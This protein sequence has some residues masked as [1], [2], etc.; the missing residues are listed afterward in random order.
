MTDIVTVLR[1]V[2]PE[3]VCKT[4]NLVNGGL[5]KVAVAQ[6]T[7][8]NAEPRDAST[9]ENMRR[10]LQDAS[11]TTNVALA[12]GK[13]INGDTPFAVVPEAQLAEML[14][15]TPGQVAGGVHVVS[16]RRIAA[17]LKRGF[18][19][20]GWVL[21]DAD[22]P[23]GMPSDWCS[24]SIGDRL[25]LFEKIL[26]GIS[27]CERIELRS[28]SARV[29]KTG[30]FGPA[31]HAYIRLSDPTKLENLRSHVQIE[32]V[33]KGLAFDSPR[34]SR[35][36]PGRVIGH[37]KRT[38]FD[39]AVWV[40]GRLIF[41]AKPDVS[42][43]PGYAVADADIRIVNEGGGTLDLGWLVVV[44]KPQ[45]DEYE[46]KTGHRVHFESRGGSLMCTD[47]SQ[48]TLDTEVEVRGKTKPLS[49][50]LAQVPDDGKLRC[51]TPFRA[52]NSEAA[53]IA[54]HKD[55]A[56]FLYDV[57]TD[58]KYC[59]REETRVATVAEL[60]VD[61]KAVDA[62]DTDKIG[63]IAVA[64][65]RLQPVEQDR[66]LQQLKAST[67]LSVAALRAQMKGKEPDQLSVAM[68]VL[69]RIG[70]RNLLRAADG[71]W[72]WRTEGVWSPC[73]DL[74]VKQEVQTTIAAS[75]RDVSSALVDGVAAVLGTH[76]FAPDHRF[77]RG[78]PETVNCQNGEL[79]LVDGVW[80]LQPHRRELYRTTQIPVS[81]DPSAVA[82]KFEAFLQEVFQGDV[83]QGDK[84][85]A[86]LEM[87]GYSLVAHAMREKFA[88]LIG[89][90]ANGKSVLLGVLEALCGSENTAGVQPS[91]FSNTFQRAHLQGKLVNIVTELGEGQT[92]ADAE[93]KGIVSGEPST[94]EHKFKPPFVMRPFATCWFGTNHMP[95]SKDH[96]GA[97]F[98]RALILQF[99]RV[100]NPSEQDP[101]LKSKLMTELPGILNLCLMAY[102]KAV[103][104]GFT[105][106]TS[107]H[108]ALKAWRLDTDQVAHFVEEECSR[109][110]GGEE[111]FSD[112]YGRYVPWVAENSTGK[113]V[114]KKAFSDRLS[115][116]GLMTEKKRDGVIVKGL[117]LKAGVLNS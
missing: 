62:G 1:A 15:S 72:R 44:Q 55:G 36:D 39:T 77:N 32:A 56:P 97:L 18:E 103:A 110:F 63:A 102:A 113:P 4:Y 76:V 50:W 80:T 22:N 40:P 35:L 59:L 60:L 48:L 98:R 37:A 49:E 93:L 67:R 117:W 65:G 51:E 71:F 79:E 7:F 108:E 95:Q 68:D 87:M 5:Q 81:Y 34:L 17:R 9:A 109:D 88:I 82:P 3:R 43:A 78:A 83:D 92:I 73:D 47:Y 54:R 114:S 33:L 10:L 115:R 89:S 64:A 100:F 111:R 107:S 29:S 11:E 94:V 41:C 21:F 30:V 2:Q 116:M 104:K 26:P 58:T 25:V 8:A 61:A 14:S 6:I 19:P 105:E 24:L 38:L 66:V 16:G 53:F 112:V 86:V 74:E 13:W 96:S 46:R 42:R 45:L 20:S 27:T 57:G 101:G 84:T 70:G 31:S 28:S 52:S 85:A 106:P 99:N 91:N 12:T 69:D 75:G 23:E 90:G